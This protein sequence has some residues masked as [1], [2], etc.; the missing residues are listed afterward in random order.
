MC[1]RVPWVRLPDN[2]AGRKLL[3]DILL[4][5]K[6]PRAISASFHPPNLIPLLTFMH[7]CFLKASNPQGELNT[8]LPST[9]T[10]EESN[11][12]INCPFYNIHALK[13]FRSRLSPAVMPR[14]S[15]YSTT[16]L[17]AQSNRKCSMIQ[18][19]WN[20]F[21]NSKLL[22]KTTSR[23]F[24]HGLI[25]DAAT[26]VLNTAPSPSMYHSLPSPIAKFELRSPHT[27][28]QSPSQASA[29]SH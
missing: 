25:T 13:L 24:G 22:S 12:F 27:A 2:R 4:W 5:F 28:S 8:D 6:G 26:T 23:N 20:T 15:F 16:T 18:F 19:Y 11:E 17:T 1:N 3:K 14:A 7:S 9:D 29:V 10:V 21:P